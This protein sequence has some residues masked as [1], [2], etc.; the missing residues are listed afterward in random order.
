[1]GKSFSVVKAVP[2]D[3]LHLTNK[4]YVCNGGGVM[5]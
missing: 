2:T 3:G 5:L 1:M 4:T